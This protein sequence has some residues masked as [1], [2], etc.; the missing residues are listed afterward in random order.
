MAVE[1]AVMKMGAAGVGE[2][3]LRMVGEVVVLALLATATTKCTTR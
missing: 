2:E 1:E 3:V